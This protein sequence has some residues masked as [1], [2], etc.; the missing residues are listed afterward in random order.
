[1]VNP[2]EGSIQITELGLAC[3]A[4]EASAIDLLDEATAQFCANDL[5]KLAKHIL[6]IAGTVTQALVPTVLAQYEQLAEP[7][8][9]V[10]FGACAISGGPYWDSYSVVPGTDKLIPVDIMVPGC[11]PAPEDLARALNLAISKATNE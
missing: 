10:A 5:A 8:V 7:K 3:C 11:P 2:K 9:V 4:V 6:V 1:M